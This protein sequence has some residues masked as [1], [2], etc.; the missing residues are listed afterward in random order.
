[1]APTSPPPCSLVADNHDNGTGQ[2]STEIFAFFHSPDQCEDALIQAPGFD[3]PPP[4]QSPAW[5]APPQP[6]PAAPAP[7]ATT[8]APAS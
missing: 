8:S 5:P 6:A 4:H 2:P 7:R 3:V 1:M